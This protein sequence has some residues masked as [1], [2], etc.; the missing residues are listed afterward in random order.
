M[1]ATHATIAAPTCPGCGSSQV[2]Q[3]PTSLSSGRT[4]VTCRACRLRFWAERDQFVSTQHASDTDAAARQQLAS[5]YSGYADGKRIGIVESAWSDTIA[6]LREMASS[7]AS[8]RLYDV[9]AGDG[10]FLRLAEEYGFE[11]AGNEVHAGAVQLAADRY[12]YD[13]ALGDL[14]ELDLE[15]VHDALTMWC[16]LVHTDDVDQTLRNCR[17]LLRPGGTMFLQT[18]HWTAADEIALSL[19]RATRGRVSRVVDRRVASHHWQLHTKRSMQVLLERH[20][21][22]VVEIRPR[23][24]YSLNSTLYMQSLGVPVP[25]ARRTSRVVDLAIKYGPVPRIVLDVYARKR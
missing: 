9:G 17:A 13:L 25:L 15:P 14:S 8:P 24:R 19:L 2:A 23:A 22:D 6:R 18:P 16:V 12:G 1:T 4:V 3:H 7:T 11:V 10:A 5:E 21:F 20:G